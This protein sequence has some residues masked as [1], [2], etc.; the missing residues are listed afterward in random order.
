MKKISLINLLILVLALT[1]LPH[2]GGGGGGGGPA[3]VPQPTTAVLTLS[4][5]I[6]GVL[7]PNTI[8]TG[9]EATIALPA[10][11]TVSSTTNAP[12]TDNGVVVAAGAGAAAGTQIIGDYTPA[13]G[14][15]PGT[16]R[17]VIVNQNGFSAGEFC[18]VTCNIAAG[19]NISASEFA[20]PTFVA[21]GLVTSPSP[22]TVDL[23]SVMS[24]TQSA[25]VK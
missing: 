5:A 16:V 19:L 22:S 18:T 7:P 2:C 25:V 17:I 15:A 3:P 20:Q 1:T 6:S 9:Y 13:A 4:T 10:G 23:T 24:L 14:A 21:N 11:V 8:I 12:Q